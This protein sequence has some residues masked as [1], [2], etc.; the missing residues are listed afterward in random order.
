MHASSHTEMVGKKQ[1]MEAFAD[2]ERG[3][4]RCWRATGLMLMS[5]E[6]TDWRQSDALIRIFVQEER[7]A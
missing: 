7:Q 5:L 3:L 4:W 6:P 2:V 1:A